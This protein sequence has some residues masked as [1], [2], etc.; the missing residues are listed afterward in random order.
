MPD[1]SPLVRQW[2]LLRTLCGRSHGVT[3]KEM[4]AEMGVSE[5]TVRRDL[6]TFQRVG[7]PLTETI[8]DHGRKQWRIEAQQGQLG[9]FFT[10]DEAIAIYLGRQFLE[11]LA[12]TL[13]WEAAQ[14]A[15]KKIRAT[16][17]P[18]ALR[19][20]DRFAVM[21]HQ[22]A[23][24]VS[25]YSKKADLI[26]ELMVGIEDQRAVFITYQS[27]RA[28]EPV[29]YDVYPYGLTYHRGSL[30]LIGWAP[31]HD[32]IRHWK[33]DRIEQVEMTPVQFNRPADFD[34]REHLATS[35][36]VYH[37]EGDVLVKVWFSPRVARYVK[38]SQWHV[39]QQLTDQQDGSLIATFRLDNTE[40]IKR[41]ILSFGK[42]ATVLQPEE[43]RSEMR[44][45]LRQLL[46]AYDRD[47]LMGTAGRTRRGPRVAH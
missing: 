30:Y 9:M 40:E 26:D 31:D 4:A 23:V 1:H 10:F 21:F 19:Y 39:S 44:A 14:R 18:E 46:A 11:P 24:G 3:V 8:G 6:D 27:L 33:V 45:E 29:T 16:L 34:L 43:V 20:V 13:F 2:I 12:G 41:W 37:G 28:T 15:F 47:P 38:E 35:F 5:K 32:E 7:F 17:G 25:D 42:H 22:T 36:G